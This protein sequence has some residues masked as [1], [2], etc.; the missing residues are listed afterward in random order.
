[1][2]IKR[3]LTFCDA[4]SRACHVVTVRG[5]TDAQMVARTRAVLEAMGP[6]PYVFTSTH[7]DKAVPMVPEYEPTFG[8]HEEFEQVPDGYQEVEPSLAWLLGRKRLKKQRRA[9]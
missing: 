1:M 9:S 6:F 5:V 4:D 7:D 8:V 3:T 2:T